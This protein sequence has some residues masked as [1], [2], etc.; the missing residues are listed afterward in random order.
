MLA[1]IPARGGSKGVPHKNIKELAGKPLLAYTVE[2]AVKSGVFEKVIVST[3]DAEIADAARKYGAEIPFIRPDAISGDF[4]SSDDV[5]EHALNYF[6]DMGQDF[7]TVCKLQPTSPLRTAEHIRQAYMQMQEKKADFVVS[8]CECEHS[9]LWSGILDEDNRLDKFIREDVKRA[10]RQSLPA[11]YRLNGAIYMAKTEAFLKQK[12]FLGKNGI[13]YIM[14]QRDSVD[15]DSSLDFLFA[16][17]LI[18]GEQGCVN[19]G[20]EK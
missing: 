18:K 13:A 11:Y 9:P 2:A 16:D 17:F 3:D 19:L 5:V 14:P 12:S 20:A 15:I 4:V 8:V 6:K 7:D 10:C 1:V